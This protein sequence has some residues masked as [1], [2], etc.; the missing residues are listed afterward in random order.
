MNNQNSTKNKTQK[1][2]RN[3][4]IR[5]FLLRE[6]LIALTVIGVFCIATEAEKYAEENREYLELRKRFVVNNDVHFA[7]EDHEQKQTLDSFGNDEIEER[8]SLNPVDDG[9]AKRITGGSRDGASYEGVTHEGGRLFCEKA[10]DSQATGAKPKKVLEIDWEFLTLINPDTVGWI[11]IP[12]TNI[13]YPVVWRNGSE[14]YYLTHSFYSEEK[15]KSGTIFADSHQITAFDCRNIIIH[16]HNLASGT[17]FSQL[18]RYKTFDY[19]QEHP[20]II[21]YSTDGQVRC[22]RI[23]AV[24]VTE[25]TDPDLYYWE[26]ES[27]DTYA[28]YCNRMMQES[29]FDTG[30]QD[31]DWNEHESI[32]LSTCWRGT[33][34]RL[35]F[36][37]LEGDNKRNLSSNR[38]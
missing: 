33:Y 7:E 13:S 17:M 6:M 8:S 9:F 27:E 2:G 29:I 11:D 30:F 38:S 35:V 4:R 36:G 32:L 19:Y 3:Y 28:G 1:S 26:F 20:F 37:I 16:G 22:Y 23:A 14:D 31:T 5:Y 21:L 10:S 15:C 25:G 12:G 18:N 24:V 34:R